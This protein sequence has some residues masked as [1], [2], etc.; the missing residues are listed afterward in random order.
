MKESS[1]ANR[2]QRSS[3]ESRRSI[4]L[5][6]VKSVPQVAKFEIDIVV[7]VLLHGVV[8]VNGPLGNKHQVS[9]LV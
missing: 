4:L 2:R 8:E 6:L 9:C 7:A 5:G 1:Q 3:S